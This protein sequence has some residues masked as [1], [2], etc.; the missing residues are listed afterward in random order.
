[1]SLDLVTVRANKLSETT[2]V[3]TK[4]LMTQLEEVP[5]D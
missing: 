1:M 5:S 2:R 3:I 4:G